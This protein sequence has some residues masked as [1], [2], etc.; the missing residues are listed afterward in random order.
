MKKKKPKIKKGNKKAT[1]QRKHALKRAFER[2]NAFLSDEEYFEMT[3]LIQNQKASFVSRQSN[4]ITH[5]LLN[6]KNVNFLCVYDNQRKTIATFLPPPEDEFIQKKI[7]E[8]N[9]KNNEKAITND[10]FTC[11]NEEHFKL[12]EM[13]RHGKGKIIKKQSDNLNLWL[14][15]YKG[16]DILCTY[17]NKQ[18]SIVDYPSANS[19]SQK[20]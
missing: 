6:Y 4:R 13:I 7:N 15:D 3:K 18:H 14:L 19:S 2:Y 9:S 12:L 20:E 10:N 17:D 8:T 11:N 16:K 1:Y 5:W